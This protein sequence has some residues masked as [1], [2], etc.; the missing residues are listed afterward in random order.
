M[1][2]KTAVARATPKA[3]PNGCI[4]LLTA[5]AF[6]RSPA[7]TEFMTVAEVAG[8]VMETPIPATTK[9]RTAGQ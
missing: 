9:V 7:S 1:E 5:E 4:T 8:S 6:P 3:V 2:A